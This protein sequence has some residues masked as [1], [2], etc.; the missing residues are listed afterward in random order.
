MEEKIPLY[1]DAVTVTC[2]TLK[3]R[4]LSVGVKLEKIFILPNGTSVGSI[5][6]TD[7]HTRD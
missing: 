5:N 7:T 4:A 1:S 6:C 3:K 2:E